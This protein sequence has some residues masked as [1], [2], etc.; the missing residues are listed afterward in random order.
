MSLACACASTGCAYCT[1]L[2]PE[3]LYYLQLVCAV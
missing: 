3:L 2:L 1:Q